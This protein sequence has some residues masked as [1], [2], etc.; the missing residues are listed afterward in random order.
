MNTLKQNVRMACGLIFGSLLMAASPGFAH[1]SDAA[2]CADRQREGFKDIARWPDIAGCAGAWRIPGLHTDNPGIAPACPGLVTF[3]TL[4]PACGRKGGDDGP[5]PG[6][7]GCN[8]ADLCASGWHVCTSDAEV[9][10]RSSTGCK[11]ATKAGDQALFFATRQSTNGCGVCANGTS[12]GPECDS[13]SCTPGCLQT[14][15][16]S[17]DFF[18]CGNFG[19][20][21]TC[22]PLN[23]FSE[24]LCSGLEGSPWSCNAATTADDNGLC[25]AYTAIKTGSRFGGVLC[26]RDTCTDSDK[27]GVCDS[28]DR[29]AGTVL[30]ESLSTGSLPGMNRFADTDGDGTFNT[31][32]S[33]DGE[34]E[35]RF[36]LVDTAGC[37]CAQIV[38][39]LGMSQ[40]HAQSGCSLSTLES[41]VS[42]V[43]EN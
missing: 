29:C 12:T 33:N 20:E 17:N 22:G 38:D 40:E 15:R 35:R 1:P 9:M 8:V 30:P 34:A 26:C 3:D 13:D 23:R 14:A 32:S 39:A 37:S 19:T 31:L 10:S 24:N 36:T 2:G 4:T 25:E 21:A 41:W 5:K 27:D 18:G 7:A 28:A 16:T 6:G 43:K 42:R 11:G